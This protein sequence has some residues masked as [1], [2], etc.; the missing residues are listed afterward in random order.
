MA[1]DLSAKIHI[2]VSKGMSG[3]YYHVGL[4]LIWQSPAAQYD[5][6]STSGWQTS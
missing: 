1:E 5:V 2:E 3:T 4:D 6:N